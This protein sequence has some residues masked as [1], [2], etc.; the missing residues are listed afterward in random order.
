M[1]GILVLAEARRGEL[2][3]V[4]FELIG[5]ALELKRHAGDRVVVALLD[6]CAAA[7]AAHL[8]GEGVDEVLTVTSPVAQF[9]AHVAGR[10]LEA[11]I[12]Q[13]RPELVIAAHSIDAL[14]FAPAVAATQGL[15]FA[16]DVT[17]LWWDG[18][19]VATR[20]A[21][22]TSSSP[23]TTSPARSARCCCCGRGHSRRSPPGLGARPRGRSSSSSRMLPAPNT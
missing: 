13:E 15:G 6:A 21:Y 18:G 17:A 9:E 14:G 19:P 8:A 2:R 12:E 4:S 22:G 5:A 7:H 1:A 11:L 20:G 3:E 10:A 16:S 23:N